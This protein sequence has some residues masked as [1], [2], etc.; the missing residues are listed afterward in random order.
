MRTKPP[1]LAPI[2]RSAGQAAILAEVLSEDGPV[3]LGRLAE[4]TGLPRSTAHREVSRLAEAG[5]LLVE[6]IGREWQIRSNPDS[7][8]TAPV[9]QILAIAFGA[10][11]LLSEHFAS[12]LGIEAA[13][14]FGSFA[15]RASG[16]PG[17]APNDVDVLVI[18]D[19]D[20]RAV[21][22][23]CREVGEVIARPVNATVMS[24]MEWSDAVERRSAFAVDVTS[25]PMLPLIGEL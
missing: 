16:V 6:T 17:H 2:F 5:L 9:R 14:V 10:V 22:A 3:G 8:L 4:R 25:H 21:Y 23:A 1:L 18:G 20:V 15:A 13:V 11:P 7:P 24:R 12:I 19:P